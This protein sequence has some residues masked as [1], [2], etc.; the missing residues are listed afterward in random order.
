MSHLTTLM[1]LAIVVDAR[2]QPVEV[3]QVEGR[4]EGRTHGGEPRRLQVLQLA[5]ERGVVLSPSRLEH[6]RRHS[7]G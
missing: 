2:R 4:A 3:E 7:G 1:Y 5:H 6:A